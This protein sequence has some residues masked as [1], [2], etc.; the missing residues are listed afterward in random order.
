MSKISLERMVVQVDGRK[1][2]S[3]KLDNCWLILYN[4]VSQDSCE[5][6]K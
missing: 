2:I 6:P 4:Y 5:I 3:S 1:F